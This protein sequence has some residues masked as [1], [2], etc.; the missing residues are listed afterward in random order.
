MKGFW[1]NSFSGPK[2]RWAADAHRWAAAEPRTN[3]FDP[4]G[5]RDDTPEILCVGSGYHLLHEFLMFRSCPQQCPDTSAKTKGTRS[6]VFG[7]DYTDPQ[8]IEPA[9]SAGK[10]SIVVRVDDVP[11]TFGATGPEIATTSFAEALAQQTALLAIEKDF[12]NGVEP[13]LSTRQID[14]LPIELETRLPDLCVNGNKA[15]LVPQK[16]PGSGNRN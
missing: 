6:F 15:W 11:F 9:A 10:G 14:H 12:P 4:F 13:S 16:L 5:Y 8:A 2:D 7:I 1:R 3:G